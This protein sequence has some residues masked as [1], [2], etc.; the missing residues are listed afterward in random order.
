MT[1][2]EIVFLHG[3]TYLP[4]ACLRGWRCLIPSTLTLSKFFFLN[5]LS[6]FICHLLELLKYCSFIGFCL[7]SFSNPVLLIFPRL[8][9]TSAWILNYFLYSGVSMSVHQ[10]P[11]SYF[12]HKILTPD[13]SSSTLL[14]K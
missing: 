9:Q 5:N 11:F 3:A 4:C 7:C 13:L 14:P 12:C 8:S 6:Y 2:K 10:L 1:S